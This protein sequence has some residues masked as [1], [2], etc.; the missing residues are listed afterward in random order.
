MTSDEFLKSLKPGD[1]VG[2]SQRYDPYIAK[3]VRVTPSRQ[4]VVRHEEGTDLRKFTKDG[5]EF[6]NKWG[7]YLE[8]VAAIEERIA[9]LNRQRANGARAHAAIDLLNNGRREDFSQKRKA[10]IL[11]LVEQLETTPYPVDR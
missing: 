10:E 9:E 1:R 2:V 5:R 6:V 3:V 11:A 7:G 4:I 8:E